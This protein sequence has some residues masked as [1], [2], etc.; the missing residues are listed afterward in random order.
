MPLSAKGKEILASM[1][2]TYGSKKK[3]EEVMYAMK[4]LG[5]LTGIDN[6]R[7][8]MTDNEWETLIKLLDKFFGEESEEKEHREDA[9]T[10]YIDRT[11]SHV[12]AICD[13]VISRK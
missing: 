13:S 8:D 7:K 9:N 5:E 4:N 6:A 1:E 2:K 10:T 3:A 12:D 11:L